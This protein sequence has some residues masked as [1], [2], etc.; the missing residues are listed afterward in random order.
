MGL[1]TPLQLE[2]VR[3][4]GRGGWS[5]WERAGV[6]RHERDFRIFIVNRVAITVRPVVVGD[7]AGV[8]VGVGVGVWVFCW[9]C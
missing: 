1:D 3:V 5:T 7:G 6:H 8:K 2:V 9:I 4:P